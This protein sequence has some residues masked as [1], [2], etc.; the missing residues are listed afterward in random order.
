MRA[1][2]LM[3]PRKYLKKVGRRNAVGNTMLVTSVPASVL[4]VPGALMRE[5]ANEIIYR[6]I[7]DAQG[8]PRIAQLFARRYGHD[9][10]YVKALLDA[11][12]KNK[13][14]PAQRK[15]FARLQAQA[16]ETWS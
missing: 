16:E 2:G 15:R 11:A 7:A 8:R 12:K 5:K 13:L 4:G 9:P 1:K 6:N 10:E 3:T 14:N